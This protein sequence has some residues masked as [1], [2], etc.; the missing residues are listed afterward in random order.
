MRKN[1]KQQ[2]NSHQ[3]E[4]FGKAESRNPEGDRG[5]KNAWNTNGKRPV[6]STGNPSRAK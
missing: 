2:K 4:L 5:N 3:I 6:S 1:R